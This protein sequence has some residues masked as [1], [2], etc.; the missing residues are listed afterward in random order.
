MLYVPAP[1]LALVHA[2]L[3]KYSAVCVTLNLGA[4]VD[5]AGRERAAQG[6]RVAKEEGRRQEGGESS[7]GGGILTI[8]VPDVHAQVW[9]VSCI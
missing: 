2:F 4:V 8:R 3:Q 9:N 1:V 6:V 7:V 5:M